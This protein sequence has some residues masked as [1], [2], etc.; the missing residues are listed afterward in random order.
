MLRWLKFGKI[1]LLYILLQ[2][3][4]HARIKKKLTADSEVPAYKTANYT[5][6]HHVPDVWAACYGLRRTTQASM[7]NNT[8]N[9]FYNCW[10]HSHNM[11]CIFVFRL[12]G[13]ICIRSLNS[14]DGCW[15]ALTQG[16]HDGVHDKI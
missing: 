2:H 16:N 14:P 1:I 3:H 10:T 7:D 11:S 12:D 5:Q 9:I 4:P 6:K 13:M 15:Q 8:K